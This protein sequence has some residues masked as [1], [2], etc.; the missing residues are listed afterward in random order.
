MDTSGDLKITKGAP[1][2][3]AGSN[4]I[5]DHVSA[6]IVSA[7]PASPAAQSSRQAVACRPNKSAG[8]SKREANAAVGQA[9]SAQTDAVAAGADRTDAYRAAQRKLREAL[10]TNA[11]GGTDI[12]AYNHAA[13]LAAQARDLFAGAASDA[14]KEKASRPQRKVVEIPFCINICSGSSVTPKFTL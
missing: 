2:R 5:G 1:L 13:D 8:D 4:S 7:R 11:K 10:D 9:L 12:R 3:N 6:A 14:K